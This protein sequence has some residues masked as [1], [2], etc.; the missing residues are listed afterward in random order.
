[1]AIGRIED[2]ASLARFM[3]AHQQARQEVAGPNIVGPHNLTIAEEAP[4]AIDNRIVFYGFDTGSGIQLR[5]R[6]P[7]GNVKTITTDS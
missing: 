3:Q 2:E 7:N 5:A 6:F 1:M 4:D